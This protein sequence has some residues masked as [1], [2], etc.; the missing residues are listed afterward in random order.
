MQCCYSNSRHIKWQLNFRCGQRFLEH[1]SSG[2]PLSSF[3]SHLLFAW[4]ALKCWYHPQLFHLFNLFLSCW[5]SDPF[6]SSH[7]IIQFKPRS[8]HF[9]FSFP[10]PTLIPSSLGGPAQLFIKTDVRHLSTSR[11]VLAWLI[12]GPPA[13]FVMTNCQLFYCPHCL[14][15]VLPVTE[16]K[17]LSP[18]PQGII[19][20]SSDKIYVGTPKNQPLSY[21]HIVFKDGYIWDINRLH[22]VS[23]PNI[24]HTLS[25]N[26]FETMSFWTE[27]YKCLGLQCVFRRWG[28]RRSRAEWNGDTIEHWQDTFSVWQHILL[29]N[30]HAFNFLFEN[31]FTHSS[32]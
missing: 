14:A 17:S 32:S 2:P 13:S 29:F 30:F 7:L 19:Y 22:S 21:N 4:L 20:L 3:P 24:R 28:F 12:F 26:Y 10:P 31:S 1:C 18:D 23:K 6:S 16:A 9:S 27:A 25:F 11:P 8:P 15:L 5:F